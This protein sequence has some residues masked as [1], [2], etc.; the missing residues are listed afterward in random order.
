MEDKG[1]RARAVEHGRL[2]DS[3]I[4]YAGVDVLKSCHE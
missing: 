3:C 4:M 2:D 1:A